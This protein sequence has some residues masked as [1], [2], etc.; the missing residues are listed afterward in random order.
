[1]RVTIGYFHQTGDLQQFGNPMSPLCF[2]AAVQTKPD[3]GG[4][5]Q[6]REQRIFLK[7]HTYPPLLGWQNESGTADRN[8]IQPYFT[9]YNRLE[10]G[11]TAQNSRF[12]ATA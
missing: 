7:Y 8:F 2:G 5:S 4:Y 1:M 10:P 3:I 12:A 9:G 11:D 6:V